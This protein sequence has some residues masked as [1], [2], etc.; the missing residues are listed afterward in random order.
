MRTT[1]RVE[2]FEGRTNIGQCTRHLDL[3]LVSFFR[4]LDSGSAFDLSSK[5][6]V[7]RRLYNHLKMACAKLRFQ[8]VIQHRRMDSITT[9]DYLHDHAEKEDCVEGWGSTGADGWSPLL[10]TRSRHARVAHWPGYGVFIY[11]M[12]WTPC[13]LKIFQP[14][15]DV[16]SSPYPI[17]RPSYIT[18]Q[19]SSMWLPTHPSSM[20]FA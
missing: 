4:F 8:I 9:W 18:V 7:R 11:T 1:C 19:Q 13:S 5:P 14:R 15:A 10:Y 12:Y 2:G 3:P 6:K 16:R 17:I 20:V